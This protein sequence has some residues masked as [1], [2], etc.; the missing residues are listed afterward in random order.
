[1]AFEPLTKTELLVNLAT[2]K[3]IGVT[4]PEAVIEQAKQVTR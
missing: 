1:M 2:A 3:A 4:I